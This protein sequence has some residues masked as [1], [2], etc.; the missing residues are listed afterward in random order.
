MIATDVLVIDGYDLRAENDRLAFPDHEICGRSL[1]RG[2]AKLSPEGTPHGESDDVKSD[3]V[4]EIFPN[5]IAPDSPCKFAR[6]A[7]SIVPDNM[8][9]KTGQLATQI[10]PANNKKK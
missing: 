5:T 1:N 9:M 6:T 3:H 8:L 10:R 2:T 7:R 4:R